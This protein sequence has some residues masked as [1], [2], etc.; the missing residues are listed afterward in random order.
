MKPSE[1][2]FAPMLFFVLIVM[3]TCGEDIIAPVSVIVFVSCMAAIE[4]CV[5]PNID[6]SR[7][8]II[9]AEVFFSFMFVP[10]WVFSSV[11]SIY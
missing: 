8:I 6:N 2:L 7:R 3:L 11:F 4:F 1:S 9:P 5:N 10:L